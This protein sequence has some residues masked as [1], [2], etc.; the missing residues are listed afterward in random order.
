MKKK[1]LA[2]LA[3]VMLMGSAAVYGG[4]PTLVVI[5]GKLV[6]VDSVVQ[7]KLTIQ[8]P[9]N[10][11]D[12][13]EIVKI[14][15][16]VEGEV[17]A[18]VKKKEYK[19]TVTERGYV[20]Q[21]WEQDSWVIFGTGIKSSTVRVGC[22]VTLTYEVGKEE[23]VK[24]IDTTVDLQVGDPSPTPPPNPNP[25]PPPNPNPTPNPTPAPLSDL[26]AGARD[27]A[28][29]V[30]PA[31]KVQSAPVIATT[32]TGI[33]ARIGHDT[34]LANPR[35]I[36]VQTKVEINADLTK[37]GFKPAD[38]DKWGQ[39]LQDYAYT[40]YQAGKLTTIEEYKKAWVDLAAGLNAVK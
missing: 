40:Q 39:K 36:L 17:P 18:Y 6:K 12:L 21:F 13:G 11:V 30:G 3:A 4:D 9:S 2:L 1:L 26:A 28:I 31:D 27:W 23:I 5:D 14:E 24:K 38:W 25:T 19:W 10:N 7:P 20:K 32:L 16:K 34:G 8:V 35:Q 37:A 15:G 29:A 33:A 22:Q